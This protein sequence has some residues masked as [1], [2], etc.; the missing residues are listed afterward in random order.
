MVN[1]KVLKRIC[2]LIAMSY[3]L[4]SEEVWEIY[5]QTNSLDKTVEAIIAKNRYNSPFKPLF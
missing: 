2:A 5:T 1:D 3:A 4:T